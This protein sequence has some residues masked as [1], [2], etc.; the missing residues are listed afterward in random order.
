MATGGRIRTH[1]G[2]AS[3]SAGIS[4]DGRAAAVPPSAP[5][6]RP[7]TAGLVGDVIAVR[8][9][10]LGWRRQEATARHADLGRRPDLP[11]LMPGPRV[12]PS[13]RQAL[14]GGPGA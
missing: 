11:Y 6:D 14:R 1:T 3:K 12:S 7:M 9:P 8:P 10:D 2:P 5:L 13:G 4:G